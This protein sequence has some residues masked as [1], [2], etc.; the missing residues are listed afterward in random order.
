M[1]KGTTTIAII[2]GGFAGAVTAIQIAKA[3][4][5]Q[6]RIV[7]IGNHPELGRGIAY[8]TRNPNHLV[9]GLA[10]TFGVIPDQPLH[11]A[12]WLEKNALQ[13][14]WKLPEGVAVEEAFPPRWLYGTYVQDTLKQVIAEHR[15]LVALEHLCS[16]ATGVTREDERY[17]I[18]T[19][20]DDVTAD[21]VVICTGLHPLEGIK[22]QG[23]SAQT[24]GKVISRLWEQG[25]WKDIA[26][27]RRV[28]IVGSS[29]TALDSI[30]SA[31]DA[32]FTG[33]FILLSRRGVLVETRHDVEPWPNVLDAEDLPTTL[34]ALAYE[35]RKARRQIHSEGGHHQQLMGA[36]RPYVPA[37]WS[38]ATLKDKLLF[39]RYLRPFWENILHRA[40]PESGKRLDALKK[41]GRLD[42]KT[43]RL[44]RLTLEASGQV[45]V[46]WRPRGSAAIEHFLVDRV[47]DAHGYE[48]DW[49]RS[50]DPLV[51][52]LLSKR[53]V[54]PD[55]TG[56]GIEANIAT[57]QVQVDG[58]PVDG[59][60][61]VGHPLRGASWESNSIGEQ[62]IQA[63][64][65]ADTLGKTLFS[66]LSS[67]K[68]E[69]AI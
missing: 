52:D 43:G 9:N 23:E 10:K 28:L 37:M 18:H 2:G 22:V 60:F 65:V 51:R 27:D 63:C 45:R 57:G 32:G 14:G 4:V 41:S 67:P 16:R 26:D 39:I 34:S 50:A 59:F 38:T 1:S 25:S 36:I 46:A 29:L 30:I 31:Q 24:V 5:F 13:L 15:D 61:A 21:A 49:R 42:R 68:L 8:S 19:E 54:R 11:L 35:A 12:E 58:K 3:A 69:M 62:L 44:I 17:Q 20:Y 55:S 53:L 33:E 40:A 56:Y 64:A 48:F 47:V 6:T 7:I 66:R